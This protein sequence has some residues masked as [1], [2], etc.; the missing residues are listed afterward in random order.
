M[1]E[2]DKLLGFYYRDV[3]TLRLAVGAPW[4]EAPNDLN[5][6]GIRRPA[7]TAWAS[8]RPDVFDDTILWAFTHPKGVGVALKAPVTTDP[9][10]RWLRTPLNPGGCAVLEPGHYPGS[11]RLGL[12]RG[13]AALEQAGPMRIRRDAN[14]NDAIDA[15]GPVID[16][17]AATKINIHDAIGADAGDAASAG[18]QVFRYTQ[19]LNALLG[20]VREQAK[21]GRG[22]RISYTLIDPNLLTGDAREAALRILGVA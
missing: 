7:A 1:I 15:L 19:H 2:P 17:P 14:R 10:R 22:D 11:H 18:C 12:H 13:R 6:I 9:T 21:A 8:G 20:A 3:R 4:F 16:A 5:V